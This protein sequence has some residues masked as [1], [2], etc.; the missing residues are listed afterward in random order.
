MM[1]SVV[2]KTLISSLKLKGGT[3]LD[4]HKKGGLYLLTKKIQKFEKK[5]KIHPQGKAF[6]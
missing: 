4:P 2:S 1:V 5:S 6:Q 3:G